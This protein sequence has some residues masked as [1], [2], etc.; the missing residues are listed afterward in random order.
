MSTP[1]KPA[2]AEAPKKSKKMLI[3]ITV[4]AILLMGGG[5]AAFVLLKPAHT[6]KPAGVV[7][8]AHPVSPQ[9]ILSWV[10]LLPT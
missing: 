8:E 2:A 9:N 6:A 10:H 7:E 5:A 4:G 1:A 3:I